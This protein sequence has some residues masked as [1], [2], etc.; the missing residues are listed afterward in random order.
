MVSAHE[1]TV[2][3]HLE[4]AGGAGLGIDGTE[5]PAEHLDVFEDGVDLPRLTGGTVDPHLV[6]AGVATGHTLLG[7]GR[8]TLAGEAGL[9]GDD[10]VGGGHLDAEVVQGAALARCLDEDQLER[11]FGDGEVGV[12]GP[13]LGR[14]GG[15]E[16]GVEL[17][18][19]IELVR[20]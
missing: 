7:C 19:G 2:V 4:A 16:L 13:H 20:R 17:D 3:A 15:E 12:P 5:L 6:L 11:R 1:C 18:R 8:Q 9:G 14:F 10:L